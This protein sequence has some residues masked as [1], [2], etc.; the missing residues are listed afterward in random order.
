[1]PILLCAATEF[2]IRPTLEWIRKQGFN[3]IQV[4]ITGVGLTAATYQLTKAVYKH[5]PRLLLQAGVAGC[6]EE[7]LSLSK[8]VTVRN[9]A[10]GDLGVEENN[11][12]NSL[13]DLKLCEHNT[14]PWT[15]GKLT[16]ASII[17]GQTG[18]PIVDS[19]SINEISTSM[20]R[21]RYYK[22][23]LGASI[24]SME[25]AALH[26]VGIM[27]KI[28]FLQ[29]RSLSNFAGERDKGKWLL[30]DA[31]GNLNSELQRLLTNLLSL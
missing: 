30:K 3:T 10:I 13:F 21:I 6:L 16:N 27:E 11:Q 17:L 5:K 15:H 25:G 31:I 4:L 22:S 18:L 23:E 8:V 7:S 20:E 28:P 19:V 29:I 26:Y 1:M 24:E 12:F 2:E 9:E 14:F